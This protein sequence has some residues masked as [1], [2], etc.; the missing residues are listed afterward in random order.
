MISR[1]SRLRSSAP[2]DILS[3]PPP[4]SSVKFEGHDWPGYVP[5]RLH[6]GSFDDP[7]DEDATDLQTR[8]YLK[9]AFTSRSRSVVTMEFG[10]YKDLGGDDELIWEPYY[11]NIRHFNASN[12]GNEVV[13]LNG[14]FA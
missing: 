10:A 13:A 8:T 12:E 3:A 9:L 11:E 2:P 5:L 6:I 1:L 7:N 4:L 14:V